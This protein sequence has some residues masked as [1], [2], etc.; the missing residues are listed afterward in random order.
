MLEFKR[1]NIGLVIKVYDEDFFDS[2]KKA[3]TSLGIKSGFITG[4]GALDKV[5]L[6]FYDWDAKK[7]RVIEVDK[8][9]ELASLTGVISVDGN[10]LMLHVHVVLG[11]EERAYAGHLVDAHVKYFEGLVITVDKKLYR[12]L[13][14]YLGFKELKIGD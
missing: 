5:K 14:E 8:P 6:G 7:Y 12:V 10:D 13:N 4:I 11:D 1:C 2:I 3:L 9:L